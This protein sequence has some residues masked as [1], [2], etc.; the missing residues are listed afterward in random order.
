MPFHSGLARTLG[1][2]SEPLVSP[3]KL[4]GH[5][6]VSVLFVILGIPYTENPNPGMQV[7][8][9]FGKFEERLWSIIRNFLNLG[10]EN[11]SML[12][13]AVRV[14]ELQEMVE[15]AS[16][17]SSAGQPSPGYKGLPKKNYRRRCEQQISNAIQV[18]SCCTFLRP[19]H[20]HDS[21]SAKP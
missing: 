12:V 1:P 18:P 17:A 20:G 5:D 15:A 2:S 21:S 8:E 4:V 13:N 14:V 16:S 19:G 7:R 10:R 3:R 9:T 6:D 11:P